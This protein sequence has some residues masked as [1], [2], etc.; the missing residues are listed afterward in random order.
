MR[1]EVEASQT[2]LNQMHEAWRA[3][4]RA[5]QAVIDAYA[6]AQ[7]LNAADAATLR[8]H[9]RR[10]PDC[11]DVL[12]RSLDAR[13]RLLRAESRP[14]R[15]RAT[16]TQAM[17]ATAEARKAIDALDAQKPALW[18]PLRLREWAERR[19]RAAA[20]VEQTARAE[21]KAMRGVEPRALDHYAAQTAVARATWNQVEH[22]RR[23]RFPLSMDIKAE[24]AV[25]N[26]ALASYLD[27]LQPEVFDV[28][29][30]PEPPDEH[31]GSD[32]QEG[33]RRRSSQRMR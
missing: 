2:G 22:E 8:Q 25:A 9:C 4:Q 7:Q 10:D 11:A 12:R 5:F 33:T 28:G 6:Q 3:T 19:R 32:R 14:E 16:C 31:R 29:T 1:A 26:K 23:Q 20:K 24:M 17:L 30:A 15:R 21:R 13:A 27:G 18:K